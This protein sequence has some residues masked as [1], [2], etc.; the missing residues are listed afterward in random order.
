[1]NLHAI[2]FG[3]TESG[4]IHTLIFSVILNPS[5]YTMGGIRLRAPKTPR[6]PES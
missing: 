4:R 5:E 1:M 6:Q 3:I 2:N